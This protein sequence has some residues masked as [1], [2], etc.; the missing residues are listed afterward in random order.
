[1][2]FNT[3]DNTAF[4]VMADGTVI[5]WGDN[6]I[7]GM[8]AKGVEYSNVPGKIPGLH[9]VVAVQS[10]NFNGWALLKDGTVMGWGSN[11]VKEGV[12]HQSYHV[13]QVAA[14]GSMTPKTCMSR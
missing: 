7:G 11:V 6:R 12:Y 4:A 9:D 14:L 8:G 13:V 3:S 1:V 5:G 10:G 2:C